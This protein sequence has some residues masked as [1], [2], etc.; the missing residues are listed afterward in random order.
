MSFIKTITA[1][2]ILNAK[3]EPTVE[4]TI[5]LDNDIRA[6]ASCP[7]GTSV[8][9]YEALDLKDKDASRYG[10]NG[11][12]KAIANI[13]DIVAPVLVGKDPSD[14]S[15]IDA[16]LQELDGTANKSKLGV[17]AVLPIS[18]A[19]A[20]SAA[21]NQHIPLYKYI[22]SLVNQSA[23]T[24]PIPIFNLINGG[25]HAIGSF[26]FQEFIVVPASSKTYDQA[27]QMI[28]AI[29]LS[30]KNMLLLNNL[31][32]LVGDEG[33]FSPNLPGN[34]NALTFLSDAIHSAGY[35]VSFDAY[36]GI[37]AASTAFYKADKYHLKEK[38]NPYSAKQLVEYYTHLVE[39]FDMIYME[40]ILSEDDWSGWKEAMSTLSNAT[41]IVGD[42]L[43]STNPARLTMAIEQKAIN[44]TIIKPN[45]IGTIT[46]TLAV[47]KQ[48]KDAGLKLIVSHRSGETNDDFIADFAVGIG[49]AYCKFGA[50]V[51]GER[52]AKYNRL[53]EIEKEIQK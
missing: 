44:A 33:G 34:K 8:S 42:D 2:E 7:S 51:R 47:I 28:Y 50:P 4:V 49:A 41:M 35:R 14:Q 36:L 10:G 18:I 16:M 37:D 38:P 25:M 19:A 20:K 30:L 13:T 32:T 52:V 45:Q 24:I 17:N 11:V 23:F 22:G 29:R 53:S 9:S 26:D 39:E 15:D 46:Q 43:I 3:G 40:D 12:L 21:A 1:S 48:A 31:S 6:T 27:L 5:V